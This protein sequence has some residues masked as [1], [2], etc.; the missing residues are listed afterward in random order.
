MIT[1]CTYPV[2]VQVVEAQA[3]YEL[4]QSEAN[5]KA[6]EREIGLVVA[7]PSGIT[8]EMS[9]NATTIMNEVVVPKFQSLLAGETTA[10]E[11]YDAICTEAKNLFG[12][13]NCASGWIN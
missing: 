9:S 6:S 13:E 11:V 7:P 12:E 1:S 8:A 10:Q 2:Y 5:A 4:D 3:S